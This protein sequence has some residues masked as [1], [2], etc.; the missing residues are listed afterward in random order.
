MAENDF[1]VIRPV[2]GPQGLTSAKRREGGKK[3]E[4][5]QQ[6]SEFETKHK[7][8]IEEKMIAEDVIVEDSSDIHTV[9]Y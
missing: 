9:D 2:Q 6:D 8:P 1:N 4:Q 7:A 5:Q 3:R